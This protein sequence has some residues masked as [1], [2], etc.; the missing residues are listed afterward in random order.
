MT[1]LLRALLVEDS[2][3]DAQ[4]LLRELRHHGYTVE[5]ERVE[6][7]EAMAIA[8]SDKTWDVILC[9]YSLP[10]FNAMN[11]LTI[12]KESGLNIPFLVISGTIDEETA[13][14]LLKAGADDFLVKGRFARLVSAIERGIKAAESRR[15][16]QEVEAERANLTSNLE[17]VNAEL[18]HV[19]YT[20]FHDLRSPLVII[21]GFLEMLKQ[22]LQTERRDRIQID[23]EHIEAST[24]K[25]DK[26]LSSSLKFAKIGTVHHPLEEVD[27]C[28]LTQEAVR[29][30]EASLRS[31]NI[32]VTISPDLPIVYGDRIHLGELLK[33]LIENAAKYT[34]DQLTPLI[35]IGC[36]TRDNQQ[37]IFVRDNGQGIDPRYHNRIF[38]LFEKLEPMTEGSGIGLALAKRIVEMHGGKIWVESAGEGQGSTFYFTIPER[39]TP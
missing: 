23:I 6:T 35:E 1:Q 22:D 14:T 27:L 36:Q 2:E 13:V 20:A 25:M 24:D 3:D 26:V 21:K 8:L 18:Q 16:R 19:L 7:R 11:A 5:H 10:Q 30:L 29:W 39:S 4:L 34:G 33:S 12:L 28:G 38:N 32:T 37:V 15:L 9:D 17:V 31:K